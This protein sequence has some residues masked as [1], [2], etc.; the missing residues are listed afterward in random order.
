MIQSFHA[1]MMSPKAFETLLQKL[2][3][4]RSSSF[5][6]PCREVP[7]PLRALPII[8][9]C[10]ANILRIFQNW[11]FLQWLVHYKIQTSS[12]ERTKKQTF[13][14]CPFNNWSTWFSMAQWNTAASG[15]TNRDAP[16]LSSGEAPSSLCKDK[17][18]SKWKWSKQTKGEN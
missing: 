17:L 5:W 16:G 12:F 7:M 15:D 14:F 6:R 9:S 10:K 13:P 18:K 1:G 4:L 11:C 8:Y 3:E 2:F